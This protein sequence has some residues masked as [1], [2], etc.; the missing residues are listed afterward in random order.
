MNIKLRIAKK[1]KKKWARKGEIITGIVPNKEEIPS[2]PLKHFKNYLGK[3]K[4][5]Q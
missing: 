3:R 1:K 4:D 5:R 2:A